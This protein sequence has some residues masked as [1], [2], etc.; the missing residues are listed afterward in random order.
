MVKTWPPSEDSTDRL[1]AEGGGLWST[2]APRRCTDVE[3]CARPMRAQGRICASQEE[4][5]DRSHPSQ[6]QVL[7]VAVRHLAGHG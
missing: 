1:V 7:K 5:Q 2:T 3:G 4:G 6:Q